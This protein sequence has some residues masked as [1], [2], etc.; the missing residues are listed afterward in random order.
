[1][2][3]RIAYALMI[4][5][6]LG[7]MTACTGGDG[8]SVPAVAAGGPPQVRAEIVERHAA[9]FDRDLQS[10]AAGSQQELSAAT[11]ILGHLQRAGYGARLE[12]VPVENLVNSTD[13][14][15]VPPGGAVSATVV[16]VAYDTAAGT[17][18]FGAD[19]GLFLELARALKVAEPEHDVLFAALGAE[20]TTL[21][22]GHLG[23]RRLIGLLEEQGA[24][25]FV[26]TIGGIGSGPVCID[27]SELIAGAPGCGEP[28][29][30]GPYAEAGFMHVGASGPPK[31][32]GRTL[33]DL[34]QGSKL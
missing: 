3:R 2:T 5:A 14:L 31:A 19:I 29:T 7:A 6:G 18:D 13:V 26:I 9:Q 11:Y 8:G 28:A 15:A 27:G 23:S 10:R 16:A 21:D 4:L 17:R 12:A 33:L 32:L 20:N 30:A 24:N 22:G 25:P 34:L 1:M